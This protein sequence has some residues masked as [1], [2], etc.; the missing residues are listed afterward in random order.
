[1]LLRVKVTCS[2]ENHM[3]SPCITFISFSMLCDTTKDLVSGDI[4]L[5]QSNITKDILHDII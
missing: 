1:M 4:T 5:A 3:I 2:F